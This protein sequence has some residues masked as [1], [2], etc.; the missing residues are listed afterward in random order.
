MTK[1]AN[2]WRCPCVLRAGA[3]LCAVF[4][5]VQANAARPDIG[6]TSLVVKQVE[7]TIDQRTRRLAPSDKVYLDEIVETGLRSASEL[8]LAD[9]TRITVGP[10]S[11]IVLDRFVY[12]PEPGKGALVLQAT[13]GVFRFI[14]GNMASSNYTIE[15]SSVTV[16]IRGT[17][18]VGAV[19]PSDGAFALILESSNSMLFITTKSGDTVVLDRPGH[20]AIALP[21]GSV[22]SGLAPDW[23]VQMVEAMDGTV[24]TANTPTPTPF[25]DSGPEDISPPPAPAPV[26]PIPDPEM[27]EKL[28]GLLRA[29][30]NQNPEAVPSGLAMALEMANTVNARGEER[31]EP[32]HSDRN[33]GNGGNNGNGGNGGGNGGNGGGNSGGNGG[34]GSGRGGGR[35]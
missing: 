9:D 19:R 30:S 32:E 11:K 12:D 23:A 25:S 31:D 2:F 27:E 7:G 26:R 20:A 21:D 17:I 22:A 28:R 4:A 16:G 29:L 6:I 8:H 33:G 24:V 18:F 1:F 15:A 13:E 10:N 35:K 34:N 5:A 14:S 3:V